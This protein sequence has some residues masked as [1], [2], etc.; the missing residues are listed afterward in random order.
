MTVITFNRLFFQNHL[1][2][3]NDS[4]VS[5]GL[6]SIHPAVHP[7]YNTMYSCDSYPFYRYPGYSVSERATRSIRALRRRGRVF[8]FLFIIFSLRRRRSFLRR[9][10]FV[11]L[12]T[13]SRVR[14]SKHTVF[15]LHTIRIVT[16]SARV[17]LFCFFGFD[18]GGGGAEQQARR[19]RSEFNVL[20]FSL[21]IFYFF[22]HSTC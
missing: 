11:Y 20:F 2:E 8:C 7:V 15:V 4:T 5:F 10:R 6:E 18:S 14:H 22:F 12:H 19:V 1:T 16:N 9:F 3:S 21:F 17:L 13:P